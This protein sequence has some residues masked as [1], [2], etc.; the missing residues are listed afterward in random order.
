MDKVYREMTDSKE[1]TTPALQAIGYHG[2]TLDAARKIVT[3]GFLLSGNPW[4]WLGKGIYFWQDAPNRARDWAVEWH[5]AKGYT[6]PIEVVAARIAL[7]DFVD[8][9]DQV[10]MELVA[11]FAA[12]FEVRM[13]RLRAELRNRYPVHRLDCAVFNFLTNVLSSKGRAVRGY[14]AACVE[15]KAITTGSPIYDRSHVQLAVID[16][17]AILEKWIV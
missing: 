6:G 1:R 3:D 12:K 14:R 4:E 16:Q 7:I 8:L 13:T 9:L 2:T 5:A 10:D 11:E 15:G 17:D